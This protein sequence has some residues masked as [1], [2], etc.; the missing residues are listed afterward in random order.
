MIKD[1]LFIHYSWVANATYIFR[2]FEK[3]GYT[4]DYVTEKEIMENWLPTCQYR[5]VVVYLHDYA[6][7]VNFILENYLKDSFMV[8]HDDT[9]F[10][11]VM[12]YYSRTPNL[13]LQREL[14]AQSR[15]VHNAPAYPMHFPMPSIWH[16][17]Y[18]KN[19]IYDV[20]FLGCPNHPR[21]NIFISTIERLRENELK[22]LN[23]FIKYEP[24]RNWFEF[25]QIVNQSKIGLNFPG[26]SQ[27][28]LR[29]WELASAASCIIMPQL[30]I[31]SIQEPGREFNQFVPINLACSDL[32]GKIVN[33]LENDFWKQQ[34]QLALQSYNQFHSPEK[35]FER[36]HNIVMHH[37]GNPRLPV[38]S[39]DGMEIYNVWRNNPNV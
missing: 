28:S 27:D 21:R 37:S 26:N 11:D 19:K 6:P 24:T 5:T 16:D 34:G 2:S 15:N 31:L 3:C 32:K 23:W 14:T 9:D 20:C 4:C 8:Q 17:E 22:H 33:C 35:C 12:N 25:Q 10:V 36:Y 18:Q 29:I 30:K 13:I 7:R 1:F 38:V 39:W